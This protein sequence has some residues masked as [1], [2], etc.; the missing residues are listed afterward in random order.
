[1]VRKIFTTLILHAWH[2]DFNKNNNNDNEKVEAK[3]NECM[4]K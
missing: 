2:S 3:T 1:M 4:Q